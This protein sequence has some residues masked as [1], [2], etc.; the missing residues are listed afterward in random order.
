MLFFG[1]FANPLWFILLSLASE[2]RNAVLGSAADDARVSAILATV[3]EERVKREGRKAALLW[4]LV[5][6]GVFSLLLWRRTD[7]LRVY[8]GVQSSPGLG[9]LV[10]LL[11][12]PPKHT[13]MFYWAVAA[14]LYALAKLFEF[15][16]HAI[17]SAGPHPQRTHAQTSRRR[18]G[19]LCDPAAFPDLPSRR[20]AIDGRDEAGEHQSSHRRFVSKP[21]G[22]LI[23]VMWFLCRVLLVAWATLAIY[24]SNLPWAG[25]R[26][27]L[28]AAFAAFAIWALLAV[29]PAAHAGWPSSWCFSAWSR[30]GSAIPP[31]HDRHGGRKSR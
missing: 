30:G 6:I 8:A 15:D 23:A 21:L 18:R 16:D 24:Y 14:A 4:S 7:D 2:R 3:V 31:S 20:H 10:L 1:I 17:D 29:P 22:W 12:F 9:L 5:P 25:L 28:A 13:G 19:P 27:G 11:L 26:L